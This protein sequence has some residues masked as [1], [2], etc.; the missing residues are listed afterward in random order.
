M[1]A[2]GDGDAAVLKRMHRLTLAAALTTLAAAA[3]LM[4]SVEWSA[5]RS[6]DISKSRQMRMAA[7]ALDREIQKIPYDQE[8]VAI[9]DDSVNNVRNVFNAN[10]V[11][12]NLG[13]WMSTYFKH[14]RAYVLDSGDRLLYEMSDGKSA[15]A[16]AKDLTPEIMKLVRDLR[17]QISDGALDRFQKGDTRIPRS[18]DIAYVDTH[19]S[20]V[21]VM[22]L[23]PHSDAVSQARGSEALLIS[24]RYLD[25]SFPTNLEA[26]YLLSGAR[27]SN[28]NELKP[29]ETAYPV[30]SR[31]KIR[32]GNL[33][34]KSE[35]PGRS[36]LHEIMPF[37]ALGLGAISV[38]MF[39]V[40]RRLRNTCADLVAGEEHARHLALH[41]ALTGLPNRAFFIEK[42]NAAL[43]DQSANN[44]TLAVLFLD[45]DRF[46]QVN[47][48]LGHAV[49]DELIVYFAEK[50]G[51]AISNNGFIARMGGDEFA[52]LKTNLSS[53]DDLVDICERLLRSASESFE[54]LDKRAMVGLSIGVTMA[55]QD[56]RDP[57]E[58]L[59]KADIA[60]Y[61]A[62]LRGGQ[63]YQ[64]FSEDMSK[65]LVE[66]QKLEA[67][68]R[69]ALDKGNELELY[70][71]P[72][73]ASSDLRIASVESL[74]R[75]NHPSRGL[76]SPFDF[77]AIAEEAGLIG[78]LG[79]WVLREACRAAK[80]WRLDT[81][82]VNVSPL[83]LSQPGFPEMVFD[84]LLEVGMSPRKLELEITET[85]LL[86]SSNATSKKALNVLRKAGV[87]IALDDFG[88]GY[89]S[90]NNLIALQ[91]DCVKIDRSFLQPS[92]SRSVIWAIINMAH[93]IGLTVTAEGV[94]TED[95]KEF[96][97]AVGCDH[98]QGYFLSKPITEASFGA[99]LGDQCSKAGDAAAA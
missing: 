56:G 62:K 57:S 44:G 9:W 94:E 6:D 39:F 22:P 69:C 96:L 38:A 84:I 42:L 19:P 30:V 41:D 24:V 73:Y 90:L 52:I 20:I 33:V 49:G 45:L 4:T 83:Q 99:L 23:V 40:I 58:L 75:W 5:H 68:L 98:M 55:P 12:V 67:E 21:S 27:F 91:V 59:R 86:D 16:N 64:I 3:L 13:V 60:L 10:W 88:T 87:R 2:Q 35:L 37:L 34:W 54:T 70:F 80:D 7:S 14:D 77:I 50:F 1:S 66:R 8:S 18:V 26:K 85:A 17:Q 53:A 76:V 61:Q 82:A 11:D 89:S 25:T 65:Q 74:I 31:D 81:V 71:Q 51:E 97:I 29:G 78:R 43:S 93:A 79:E 36:I 32:I 47:D 15:K 95:Q 72:V 28:A 63:K 48:T 46:K 92:S